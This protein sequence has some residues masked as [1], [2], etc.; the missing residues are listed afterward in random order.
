[1]YSLNDGDDLKLTQRCQ[2][3]ENRLKIGQSFVG[4]AISEAYVRVIQILL[5]PHEGTCYSNRGIYS[6]TSNGALRLTKEEELQHSMTVLPTRL[7]CWQLSPDNKSFAYGGEEVE[8][9]LWDTERAFSHPI[10]PTTGASQKRKREGDLLP[11]ETWRAKNVSSR[12]QWDDLH[13][14]GCQGTK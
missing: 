12:A 9:S 11:A 8:V 10:R 5:T 7:C 13:S 14:S 4:L 2:W 1:M 6:C 3:K